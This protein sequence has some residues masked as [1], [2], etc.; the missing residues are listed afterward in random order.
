MTL[1]Y[2]PRHIVRFH[3][4]ASVLEQLDQWS[5]NRGLSRSNFT[6]QAVAVYLMVLE[7]DARGEKLALIDSEHRVL[8]EI[9]VS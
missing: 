4:P 8:Y 2:E 5:I 9:L 3:L 7:A 1:T 6:R